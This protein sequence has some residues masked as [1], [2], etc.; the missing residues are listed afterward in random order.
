MVGNELEVTRGLDERG[1][2]TLK[3]VSKKYKNPIYIL[4]A[5]N[6]FSSYE[7]KF[8][9]GVVPDALSGT[10][11]TPDSA[12]NFVEKYLRNKQDSVAVRRDKKYKRNHASKL[13]EDNPERI[14]QRSTD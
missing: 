11:T 10:Y 9:K 1:F 2:E 4:K 7:V 14:Q 5:R 8:E 13:S 3:I 12:L 6:G